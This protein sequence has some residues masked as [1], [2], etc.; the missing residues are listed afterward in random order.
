MPTKF[1]LA[2]IGLRGHLEVVKKMLWTDELTD[3]RLN[4]EHS[5][6][7]FELSWVELSCAKI[8]FYREIHQCTDEEM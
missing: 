5:Q 1:G 2:E 3:E 4:I 6:F 7:E 8:T